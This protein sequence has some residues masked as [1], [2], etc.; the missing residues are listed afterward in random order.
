MS[1]GA[2]IVGGRAHPCVHGVSVLRAGAARGGAVA[3]A[4]R[5]GLRAPWSAA[6]ARCAPLR[7][8][9]LLEDT[10]RQGAPPLPR[11]PPPLSLPRSS[12]VPAYA[13]SPRLRALALRC[14]ALAGE[15]RT[16]FIAVKGPELFSKYVGE[17]EQKVASLFAKVGGIY[18]HTYICT[19][20]RAPPR[21][22]APLLLVLLRLLPPT[23]PSCSTPRR[24]RP[25]RPSSFLTRLTHSLPR[26][27]ARRR[28]AASA[29]VC[30]A[31]YCTRWTG[32][33]RCRRVDC[34]R[35]AY[36]PHAHV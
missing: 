5:L 10:R 14:Q 23:L 33:C 32:C 17:S 8:A 19:S 6:A 13:C 26:A 31:S 24:A 7:P 15:A 2:G 25:H 28:A 21:H 4:A 9:R 30:S 34:M 22:R 18:A 12:T 16:N 1:L 29:R 36:T 11:S 27:T 35:A 3:A 20:A